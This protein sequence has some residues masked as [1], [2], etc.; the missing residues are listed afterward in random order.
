MMNIIA[1]VETTEQIG[2]YKW[3][4]KAFSKEFNS[5]TNLNE[6]LEWARTI[7]KGISFS[8]IQFSDLLTPSR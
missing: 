3:R 4:S 6:I 1:T 7:D 5:H 8:S 2:E